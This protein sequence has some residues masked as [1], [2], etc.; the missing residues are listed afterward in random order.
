MSTPVF[1]MLP[2]QR[3]AGSEQ[4]AP[5]VYTLAET[6]R[7]LSCSRSTIERLCNRGELVAIGSG[8]LRRVTYESIMD[9]LKRQR[10]DD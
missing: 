10:E 3:V 8:K 5:L 6:G 7:L 4:L 9:Y 1:R 2:P